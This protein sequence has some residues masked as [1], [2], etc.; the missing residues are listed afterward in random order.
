[1]MLGFFKKGSVTKKGLLVFLKHK[2]G[3]FDPSLLTTKNGKDFDEIGVSLKGYADF[4]KIL[5]PGYVEKHWDEVES[6]IRDLSIFTDKDIIDRR[7]RTVHGLKDEMAI[8]RIKSLNYKGFGRLSKELL[9][10]S[11]DYLDTST[12][13]IKKMSLLDVMYE[14]GKNLMEVI[15]DS[16]YAFGKEILSRQQ[17]SLSTEA[18]ELGK[19]EQVKAAVDKLYV[20][21]SLKRPLLQAYEIVDEVQKIVGHPIDEY[22]VECT[23]GEDPKEKGKTKPSRLQNLLSLY[24]KAASETTKILNELK[25]KDNI[26]Y[27]DQQF[28]EQALKN[29]ADFD[30]RYA[31]LKEQ[32]VKHNDLRFRSDKL[33]F[34][35]IQLGRCMYSLKPIELESLFADEQQYDID[36]IVP[37]SL[38]KDDSLDNRVLVF[39]DYNRKKRDVYPLPSDFLAHDAHAFYVY[40]HRIGL[41]GER[42]LAALTRPA[43]QELSDEELMNFTNRQLVSTNQAVSGLINIL[44]HFEK[45]N[46]KAPEVIY[47]KAKLVSDFRA[48]FDLLKSRDANDFHHAHDAYLNIVVGRANH[49]YFRYMNGRGWFAKMHNEKMTTNPDN[50]FDQYSKE[51]QEKGLRKEPIKDRAGNICW[52]YESSLAQIKKD[53]YHRFDIMVTVR[54][55]VQPGLFSK[56]SIHKKTDWK[57][58]NLFPIRNGLN[59][60]KYGGYSDLTN[61]FFTIVAMKDK[62]AGEVPML[63]PVANIYA[64]PNDE[65]AILKYANEI[66]GV[67]AEKV[68]VP[69]LRINSVLKRGKQ[70]LLLAG[71]H[72]YSDAICKCLNE[73]IFS[74]D[75]IRTIRSVSKLCEIITK[76]LKAGTMVD[77]P[78]FD[79]KVNSYFGEFS[80]DRLTIS[81]AANDKRNAPLVVTAAELNSLYDTLTDK[82]SSPLFEKTGGPQNTAVLLKK[83]ETK[84]AFESLNIPKK[85]I[86]LSEI[87]K[88]TAANSAENADLHLIGGPSGQ[89]KRHMNGRDISDCQVVSVSVTGFYDKVIFPKK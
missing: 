53:I 73:M 86:V 25:E 19:V 17:E 85:A 32:A 79:V 16:H 69:C 8:R 60:A 18:G 66:A 35:Y 89:T 45:V 61:G 5:G 54:E 87:L 31:E 80:P 29:K 6:I 15:N 26:T 24:S 33:F 36:H 64:K 50:I 55:F 72:T 56:I 37:Q 65:P 81:P 27:A 10:L 74:Q 51:A 28:K 2:F 84:L 13:E 70:T 52:D 68:L 83:P 63:L 58:G 12:G 41:I 3:N 14:T 39:Q 11:S 22:Y 21:P 88:E 40:L 9:N 46:G 59:P 76:T 30:S 1:L 20:S 42:K 34:Y 4:E 47:S 49:E 43:S 7:L 82:L 77:K 78:D 67:K 48:K 75:Q 44:Q 71:K 62:K 57:N 23:R 38:V